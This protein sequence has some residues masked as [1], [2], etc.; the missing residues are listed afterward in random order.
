[1]DFLSIILAA[2]G[3]HRERAN[4]ASDRR[5][6][7]SALSLRSQLRLRKRPTWWR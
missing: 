7:A 3:I 6:E 5:I 4:K 1:M 2:L